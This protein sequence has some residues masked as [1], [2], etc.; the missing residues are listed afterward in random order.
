MPMLGLVGGILLLGAI[1]GL[2][3]LYIWQGNR[4][5]ELTAT[6][7]ETREALESDLEVNR[8][9]GVRIEEAFSLERIAKIARERLGM[10]APAPSDIRYVPLLLDESN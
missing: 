4:L 3:F 5:K 8:I 1:S 6:Y 2:C 9:L 10:A 7:E